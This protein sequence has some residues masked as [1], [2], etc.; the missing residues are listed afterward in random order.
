MQYELFKSRPDLPKTHNIIP[1][2]GSKRNESLT[3]K[4]LKP[5]YCNT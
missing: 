3:L 4:E 2:L 5:G 1:L